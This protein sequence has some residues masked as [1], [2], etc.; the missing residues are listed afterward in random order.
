MTKEAIEVGV[1]AGVYRIFLTHF[2]QRYP[3]IPVFDERYKDR[4]CIAFDMMSVNL[5]D[6]PLLPSLLPPLK[7]LFQHDSMDEDDG[8]TSV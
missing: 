8:D 7:L 5:A 2:S 3:K 6:M 1:S 4:T